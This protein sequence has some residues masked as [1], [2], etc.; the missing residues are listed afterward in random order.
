MNKLERYGV[1]VIV[2]AM[3]IFAAAIL[4]SPTDR[5]GYSHELPAYDRSLFS[6]WEDADGDCQNKRHELLL[7]SMIRNPKLQSILGMTMSED[8]CRVITG[9]WR[10]PYTGLIFYNASLLDADHI[11]PLAHAWTHGAATWTRTQRKAFANDTFNLAIVS[12]SEN[13]RKGAKAPHEYMPPNPAYRCTYLHRWLDVKR[14]YGLT[15]SAEEAYFI[16]RRLLACR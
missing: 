15:L 7:E 3:L 1:G 4:S 14:A 8:G 12:A 5:F 11:V 10:C 13:R 6:H 2:A 16:T 9:A